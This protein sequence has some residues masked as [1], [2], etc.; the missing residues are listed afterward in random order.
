MRIGDGGVLNMMFG[1][2]KPK[3]GVMSSDGKAFRSKRLRTLHES[4][5]ALNATLIRMMGVAEPLLAKLDQQKVKEAVAQVTPVIGA[6]VS[7]LTRTNAEL[8]KLAENKTLLGLA[9]A[10]D[11][12]KI[13]DDLCESVDRLAKTIDAIRAKFG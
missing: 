7:Q 3:A 13:L 1:S 8:G 6:L 9:F 10:G 2:G 5:S 12:E 4:V 11:G